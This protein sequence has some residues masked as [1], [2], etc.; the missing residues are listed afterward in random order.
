MINL[1]EG[2]KKEYRKLKDSLL[3]ST[4]NKEIKY[5]ETEIHKLLDQAEKTLGSEPL[6]NKEQKDLYDTYKM[7]LFN[8]ESSEDIHFYR[9][10]ILQLLNDSRSYIR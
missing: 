6:F 1:D 3:N 10:K 8:A 4:S 2:Q 7:K 9:D 5:Y